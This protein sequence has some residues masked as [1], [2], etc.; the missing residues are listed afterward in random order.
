MGAIVAENRMDLLGHG[1]DETAKE[2]G[3]GLGSC[4]LMQLDEGEL[5]RPVD[6]DKEME[7]ALFCLH[8]YGVGEDGVTAFTDDGVERLRQVIE[9]ER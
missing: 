9:D 4:F 8:I 3:G 2:A 6:G 1:R 5:R 7:L